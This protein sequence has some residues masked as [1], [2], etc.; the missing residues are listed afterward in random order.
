[1]GGALGPLR[2]I[3]PAAS[4]TVLFASV[5]LAFGGVR[6]N[7]PERLEWQ[8]FGALAAPRAYASAV[9]LPTG[10]ILVFGG[11]DRDTENVASHT[12][13]LFDTRRGTA[14]VIDYPLPGRVQPV[15]A[16]TPGRVV[17]A[18]GS[19]WRGDHWD[20]VD[21][22]D[23]FV[24]YEQ[25]WMKAAP[26]IHG[27]TGHVGTVLKDGRVFVTGGYD[28]PR[29]IGTSEIYDPRTDRW[30]KVAS[31]PSVRGD[32]AITTL[33]DGR[34]MVA[35]GLE[36]RNSLPTRSSLYYDVALDRWTD[37]PTLIG[38]RVL[39]S[40]VRLPNGDLLIIGGQ[41][42]GSGS[43]ER[44]DARL[45]VFLHAGTLVLPRMAAEAAALPDGRA[46]LT[47]GLPVYP[48]DRETFDPT[49]R[50]E[51][52]DPATNLWQEV[53]PVGSGRAFARLVPTSLGIYQVSGAA[54]GDTA[55]AR[56]ERFVWR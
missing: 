10:E 44:Y 29:L 36:G 47:G 3:A 26:M 38:E 28:G 21:R 32:F 23:V 13:E 27:R 35:G 49:D 39:Q 45:G 43:A 16:L 4:A 25:R 53:A 6:P 41:R 1:M 8:P 19:E 48:G 9:A 42:G 40:Q 2:R 12:S 33:D 5:V 51:L 11:L 7:A 24:I 17:V 56:I 34:V 22:T 54:N 15:V 55:E 31:M 46:L 37:G 14:R 18:G 20:V 50:T 30:K 52:W